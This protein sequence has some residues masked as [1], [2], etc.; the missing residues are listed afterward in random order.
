MPRTQGAQGG[1]CES[2]GSRTAADSRTG[3]SQFFQA[4][5]RFNALKKTTVRVLLFFFILAPTMCLLL[6]SK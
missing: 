3:V 5:T 1:K 2:L 6:L 4:E